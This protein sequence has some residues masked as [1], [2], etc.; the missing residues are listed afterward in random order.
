ME[1]RVIEFA[2]GRE[3]AWLQLGDPSGVP[4]FGFHGTPGSRLS[5]VVGDEPEMPPGIRLIVPDRPGYGHSSHDP[6]RRL[7]DWPND[8]EL[9]AD[10]LGIERFAVMGVSGG[11]PYAVACARFLAERL[12]GVG[13]VSGVGPI[14]RDPLGL[15][16]HMMGF[17]RV[18][19]RLA[20][21]SAWLP[22][23]IYSLGTAFAKRRPERTLESTVRELPPPDLAVISRPEIRS[24]FLRDFAHY[25]STAGRAAARDYALFCRDWGF[26]LE[27]ISVPVHIWHGDQDRNVPIAAGRALASAIPG[28]VLHECPGEGHLLGFDHNDEILLTVAK[29]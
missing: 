4:V 20:R 5:L 23:L 26:R 8:V 25:P 9:L 7:I 14:W 3:L 22:A 1:T 16:E 19:F 29:G 15:T 6:H 28:A 13:V 21:R 27:D 18:M 24:T 11:G 17:N 2:D 12:V 10:H